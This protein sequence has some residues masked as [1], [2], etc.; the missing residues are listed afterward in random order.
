MRIPVGITI[1][2]TCQKGREPISAEILDISWGGALLTVSELLPTETKPLLIDLPWTPGEYI[3]VEATVMRAEGLPN[4]QYL[5]AVR[6]SSLCPACEL[7]LEKLLA[8]LRTSDITAD[9]EESTDL[10]HE[11]DLIAS[12]IDEWRNIMAQIAVGRYIL[13]SNGAYEPDESICL[14]I[15]GPD[16]IP[17]LHLRAR[18]VSVQNLT[19]NMSNWQN[20][21]ILILEFE[22]QR[23][24]LG[25]V[26]DHLLGFSR[27]ESK[28]S[29]I[30]MSSS[31]R[32]TGR[33]GRE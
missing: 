18:I 11:I 17:T 14:S 33:P 1:N 10:F 3:S 27:K 13:L 23:E 24:A 28:T 22:H 21:C 30:F 32:S 16:N 7:K 2:L 8:M 12:D 26:V 9:S 15:E 5:T 31:A 20:V 4:G 25:S 29:H 19:G 6:F